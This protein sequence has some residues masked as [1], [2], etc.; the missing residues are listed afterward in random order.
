MHHL[1]KNLPPQVGD[2]EVAEVGGK[3]RKPQG[4]H[5]V[6]ERHGAKVQVLDAAHGHGKPLIAEDEL[7]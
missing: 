6:L 1:R 2:P 3:L 7:Q 4:D 5:E